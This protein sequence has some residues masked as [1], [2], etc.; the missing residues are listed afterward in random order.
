MKSENTALLMLTLLLSACSS[1]GSDDTVMAGMSA[2]DHAH[3]HGGMVGATDSTGT[4]ARQTITLS[5]EHERALG[6]TFTAAQRMTLT[7]S[8]RTVG[9]ITVVEPRVV[10]VA[11]KVDGF[12]EQLYA[13]ATGES[14]KRGEPLLTLYSPALVAA[15]EELLTAHRLA[16]RLEAKTGETWRNAQAMLDAARR[17]LEY[18]DVPPDYVQGIEETGEVRKALPLLAPAS[19][20][21]LEKHVVEGQRVSPGDRLYRIADLS[22]VWIEGDVFEQD[23][24]FVHVGSQAHIEVSAYP[25]RHLM[26][27]VSFIYPVLDEVSRTTRVRITV[28]NA[29]GRLK[30]GMFATVFFT[31][32]IGH[33]VLAVPAGAVVRTGERNIVFVRHD[34]GSLMPHDVVLGARADDYV[35]ILSGVQEGWTIVASANFLVDAESQLGSTGSG[36]AGMQH[37]NH[38]TVTRSDASSA[39][40]EGHDHD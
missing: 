33:D 25:D 9:Q 1:T 21:L 6:V 39:G 38:E 29:D 36:S 19:G 27:R 40:H 12:V 22:E 20:V 15:Q 13:D 17:R 7:K 23:L 4:A 14:V 16:E 18:W 10:D 35:Q 32:T 30:P 24:Q 37:G 34:D 11:P 8:I 2:E 26:G 28:G 5:P 31:A 3:M